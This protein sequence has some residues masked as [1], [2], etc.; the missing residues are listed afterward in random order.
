M[1]EIIDVTKVAPIPAFCSRWV[2]SKLGWIVVY[3]CDNVLHVLYSICTTCHC[4]VADVLVCCV[5]S[6]ED[7]EEPLDWLPIAPEIEEPE[8]TGW[9]QLEVSTYTGRQI[10]TITVIPFQPKLNEQPAVESGKRSLANDENKEPVSSDL[11]PAKKPRTIDINLPNRWEDFGNLENS[12][13][14]IAV[15][16]CSGSEVTIIMTVT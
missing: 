4:N 6:E 13:K 12:T 16:L 11:P 14:G 7:N 8:D 5:C 10:R 9:G 2:W 1:G 15:Q 3:N